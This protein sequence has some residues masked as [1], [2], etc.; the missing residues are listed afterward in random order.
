[1]KHWIPMAVTAALIAACGSGQPEP[2]AAAA[3]AGDSP[4]ESAS[5]TAGSASLAAVLDAGAR[6]HGGTY[7]VGTGRA[8]SVE[9]IATALLELLAPGRPMKRRHATAGATRR[10]R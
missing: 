6:A 2:N 10:R 9:Q 5:D 3:L 7:N 4:T 1:M 8:T